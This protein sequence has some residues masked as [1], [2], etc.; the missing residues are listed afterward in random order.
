[1]NKNIFL[2]F[3][4]LLFF[5]LFVFIWPAR[6][7]EI[8]VS[9]LQASAGGSKNVAVGKKV[10]FDAAKTIDPRNS[11]YVNYYWDFGDG[12]YSSGKEVIHSYN[13]AGEYKVTLTVD[14]GFEQD[15]DEIL[16]NVYKDLIVLVADKTPSSE[17]IKNLKREA[18]R[19]QVLL[20]AIINK[21]GDA[22]YIVE[23]ALAN[24]LLED[25]EDIQNADLIVLWTAGSLGLN[26]MSKF[27]QTAGNL[28][29]FHME[30][31]GIVSIG[32]SVKANA[33]IAQ[34]T[35]DVLQPEYVMLLKDSSLGTVIKTKNSQELLSMV[36]RNNIDHTLIG[37]H[38]ERAVTKL[39][40]TNFLSYSINYLINKGVAIDNIF[41]LLM[42][43]VIATLIAVLRQILGIKTF[44]IYTPTIITLS[45]IATGLKYGLTIFL[46]ILLVAT[47][48]RFLLRRFKLLYLPRMAIVL[49]IL[50]LILLFLF[51]LGAYF[52]KT[53]LIN[54]SILPILVLLILVEKFVA[55][56]IE[57]GG[58]TAALLSVETILVSVVCY[59]I[60][61][62]EWF[63]TLI[64]SY[65][66]LV[67][68][69]I[70]INIVLGRWTGL[71]LSE[72]LRFKT[73]LRKNAKA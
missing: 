25:K 2:N 52:N 7:Q 55:V 21:Q 17:D 20:T 16:V 67:L 63:K 65:P 36:Q 60:V 69:T 73:L 45:F 3:F 49:C 9:S 11:A 1:M 35:Y 59:W 62:W 8:N 47:A 37:K 61:N 26:A 41:L 5:C 39:G 10:V 71:R 43:P 38:S 70:V 30:E 40:L 44:G 4:V 46:I 72:Y 51:I 15:K 53:G 50:A 48:L 24:A 66:E 29:D 56:Q 57:K 23:G 27:A 12:T 22:D 6:A 54:L 64:L 32:K 31:K 34:S 19:E 18:A 58:T 14:N 42:L 68:L 13:D 28:A 33:R